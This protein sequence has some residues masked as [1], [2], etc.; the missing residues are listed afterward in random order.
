MVETEG[1]AELRGR[2]ILRFI[3]S[4]SHASFQHAL[5]VNGSSNANAVKRSRF[6]TPAGSY[7]CHFDGVQRTGREDFI[8]R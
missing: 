1:R 6:L 3:S 4:S 2:Y 7:M 5:L 8:K